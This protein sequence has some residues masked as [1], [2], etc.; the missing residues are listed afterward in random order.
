MK[1]AGATDSL[2]KKVYETIRDRLLDNRLVPG[3]I[4]NRRDVAKELGVSVAP[5]LEAFLQLEI[6]GFVESLPRK[7]TVIKAIRKE[8]IWGRLLVREALE[9]EAARLYCGD[10][11]AAAERELK[12]LA[13]SLE[14]TSSDA[15][16]HWRLDIEFHRSLVSLAGCEVL[17]S[18]FVKT[19]R[20]GTFYSMNRVLTPDDRAVRE[21]HV[22]LV[23]LLKTRNPEEADRIIRSHVRSGKHRFFEEMKKT[24]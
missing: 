9:C 2:S 20:L 13:A 3:D 17:T 24:K 15:P 19:I 4:L 18:E 12:K 5:V 1:K 22:S 8:D 6:E 21:D 16:E 14:R 23:G 10:A 11:V 7:G